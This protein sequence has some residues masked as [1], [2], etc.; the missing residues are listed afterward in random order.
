M[1]SHDRIIIEN[2]LNNSLSF[3]AIAKKINKDCTTVSKEV[4]NNLIFKDSAS[5]GRVFNNCLLR[6]ECQKINGACVV[7]LTPKTKRCRNCLNNCRSHCH[8]FIEEKCARLD[9]PPY[10]CNGCDERKGCT[11][12]KHLYLALQANKKYEERLSTSRQGISITESEIHHLNKLLVPLIKQK[13]QS[14][15][16]VFINHK[17]EIMMCEKT[18]YKI[19]DMG[20][21]DVRNID[22][23]KKVRFRP[24]RKQSSYKIDKNCLDGRRY[25]DFKVFMNEHPDTAVVEMDTV[26]GVKGESCL[27]TIHFTVCSFM[28][29]VK[30]EYNDSKSVAEFFN[31]IYH[32]LGRELFMKLFPVI[33]TD[34]GTE[35]SNPEAIE[36]DENGERRTRVFYCHPS[37]PHEKGA[38]EVNHEFLRRIV[39]KG[40]SWNPYSQKDITMMMSHINSYA[41]EKLNDKTPL[42]LFTTIYGKDSLKTFGISCIDPDN[43]NLTRS[44][45]SK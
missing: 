15:H 4:K 2:G 23:P 44:L 12:T 14:I 19:I 39:P 6:N 31:R 9:K 1:N 7:C 40:Y 5:Y 24:R 33:L 32:E 37:S 3:K 42:L 29:A 28:V 35:F 25:E 43:I 16:H 11:L 27:L 20:I 36:F 18:L 38:C 17:D 26:E 10:V 34:N 45:I 41:R 30:R 21:L 13:G 8:D 22:L